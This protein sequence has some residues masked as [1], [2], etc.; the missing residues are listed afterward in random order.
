[1]KVLVAYIS[2]TGNTKKIADAIFNEIQVEKEIKELGEIENLDSY[3]LS[4]IGFP[5]QAYSPEVQ[6]GKFLQEKCAGKDIVLFM[7]HGAP[8]D[9][10]LLQEW[11][12]GCK[13]AAVGGNVIGMFNCQGALSPA[14]IAGL[15]AS[16]DPVAKER[17]KSAEE[18]AGQPDETKVAKGRT[19]AK[20]IMQKYM[21]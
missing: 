1:M 20:E 8:E 21:A 18:S 6:A 5:I 9:S 16:D 15:A 12:V 11:L 7:T 3:D 19:F 4:F 2:Q 10:E 17:A 14:L 13:E